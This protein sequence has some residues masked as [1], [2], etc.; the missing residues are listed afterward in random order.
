M[1]ALSKLTEVTSPDFDFDPQQDEAEVRRYIAEVKAWIVDLRKILL[2]ATANQPPPPSPRQPTSAANAGKSLDRQPPAKRAR[3]STPDIEQYDVL[4]STLAVRM[5][6]IEGRIDRLMNETLLR[7]Y[8]T[9]RDSVD[10]KVEA[11]F[12]S[13][14]L[15]VTTA[16]PST[17]NAPSLPSSQEDGECTPTPPAPTLKSVSSSHTSTSPTSQ[18]IHKVEVLGSEVT[19][20][21]HST[22]DVLTGIHHQEEQLSSIR[23]QNE[24]LKQNYSSVRSCIFAV[25]HG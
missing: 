11:R 3:V 24:M 6:E 16:T 4:R 5:F 15:S 8:T 1:K 14:A 25:A 7:N 18:F 20:L 12:A 22:A 10:E 13:L 2:A 19:E 21:A 17:L 23:A 9:I